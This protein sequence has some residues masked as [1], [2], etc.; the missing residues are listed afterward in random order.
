MTKGKVVPVLTMK[1]HR[2]SGGTAPFTL[3]LMLDED[4]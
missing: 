3:N 1:A 2:G 4:E